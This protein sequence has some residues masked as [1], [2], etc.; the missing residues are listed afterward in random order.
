M[1]GLTEG[2]IAAIAQSMAR[3]TKAERYIEHTIGELRGC[4]VTVD[5]DSLEAIRFHLDK[6]HG[7]MSGELLKHINAVQGIGK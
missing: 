2:Q 7:G 6:L 4:R 1:P 5:S 3:V